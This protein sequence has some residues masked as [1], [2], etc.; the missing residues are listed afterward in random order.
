M[1]SH[2]FAVPSL[3]NG[4][5]TFCSLLDFFPSLLPL[6]VLVVSGFLGSLWMRRGLSPVFDGLYELLVP[7]GLFLFVFSLALTWLDVVLLRLGVALTRIA[8]DFTDQG[9]YV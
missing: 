1:S 5:F 9:L 3:G 7:P 6:L 4:L 8:R 2:A